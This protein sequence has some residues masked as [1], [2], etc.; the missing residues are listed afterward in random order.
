MLAQNESSRFY[1]SRVDIYRVTERQDEEPILD[2]DDY[3]AVAKVVGFMDRAAIETQV[4][5]L[6]HLQFTDSVNLTNPRDLSNTRLRY[7]VRYANGRDQLAS[8]SNTVA[9]EPAPGIALPPTDIMPARRG[10][11]G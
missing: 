4:K 11:C 2:P 1:I 10:E 7:A 3:A 9:V 5:T 8:F 6:G